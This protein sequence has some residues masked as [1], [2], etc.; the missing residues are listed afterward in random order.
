MY[1]KTL[2]GILI[3]C[4]YCLTI[5]LQYRWTICLLL[6]PTYWFTILPI[7][8]IVRI[9]YY[10]IEARN[11][12]FIHAI[13]WH[14]SDLHELLRVLGWSPLAP[15]FATHTNNRGLLSSPYKDSL[16]HLN[17]KD[18]VVLYLQYTYIIHEDGDES[19]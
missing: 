8:L 1:R 12:D 5:C 7:S 17:G 9:S 18:V 13:V 4:W 3:L 2:Q 19:L 15:K 11:Q 6:P 14:R 16:H 10:T